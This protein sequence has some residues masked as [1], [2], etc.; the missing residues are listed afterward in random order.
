MPLVQIVRYIKFYLSDDSIVRVKIFLLLFSS[1]ISLL[2][3]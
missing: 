2:H 1:Q 3:F